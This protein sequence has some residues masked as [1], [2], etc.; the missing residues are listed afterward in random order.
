MLIVLLPDKFLKSVDYKYQINYLKKN[1][2]T[3]VEVH[4]LFSVVNKDWESYF[5]GKRYGKVK[6]FHKLNDWKQ[7]FRNKIKNDKKLIVIN[8]LGLH[9]FKSLLIHYELYKSKVKVALFKSP[10]VCIE[11]RAYNA[12]F[13]QK[14]LKGFELLF[15]NF[16]RLK[17]F[18]KSKIIF[19]IVSFF[20]FD[21]LIIF[22]SGNKNNILP[23][24]DAK[25]FSFVSIHS[26]DYSNHLL[27]NSNKKKNPRQNYIVFLDGKSPYFAGDSQIF[28]YKIN[29]NEK[30]WYEDLNNFLKLI[31][32]EFKSKIIIIPHPRVR[33]LKNPN[34]LKRFKIRKD[35]E[36]SAKLI[37][38]SK[39]VISATAS[40][41]VSYCVI[42]NKPFNIIFNNQVIKKNQTM[43]KDMK[44]MSKV[45]KT[46]LININ[47]GFDKKKFST[48]ID[49]KIYDKYKYDYLTS[50][51]ISEK[52]NHE[53]INDILLK[54]DQKTFLR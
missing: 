15:S 9:S 24:T 32:K 54:E 2:N 43:W 38:N 12:K 42:N 6:V 27:L 20:T 26:S 4:D 16:N 11:P 1:L 48:T 18:I 22:Y 21:E 13:Y 50:K 29:Y 19:K 44:Y 45:L 37:L 14:F 41:A 46:G 7:Y 8:L 51:K 5:P 23:Y 35:L 33:H 25:K 3:K 36:A 31:E 52:M 30:L 39:F 53:I 49:K 17:R 10:E 47:N 40:T 28:G 34:Y